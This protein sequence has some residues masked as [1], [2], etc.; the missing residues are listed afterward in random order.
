MLINTDVL[1]TTATI[2]KMIIGAGVISMP[3]TFSRLGYIVGMLFVACIIC[4]SQMASTFLIKVK[5][6][7]RRSNYPTI[8]YDITN[9]QC[10][11]IIPP[12]IFACGL[13]G[14]AIADMIILK[15]TIKSFVASIAKKE[16]KEWV[17]DQVYL[18][19]W[20]V[21]L[22]L[23][24]LETPFIRVKKIH[25]LKYL[26]FI[27]TT[28]ICFF[29]V[30]FLINFFLRISSEAIDWKCRSDFKPFNDNF[31][32]VIS[33]LPNITFALGFQSNF[34]PIYKGLKNPTDSRIFWACLVG[35]VTC[36]TF[37][38]IAGVTGFCLYG[39]DIEANF[40]QTLD[41][42]KTNILVYVVL[43]LAIVISVFC[44]LPLVYFTARNNCISICKIISNLIS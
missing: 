13:T 36:G 35:V 39:H 16:G 43:N 29:M 20:M 14:V 12:L 3:Y 5:N 28:G 10:L 30:F 15:G 11:K 27:G 32:E 38:T 6:L 4:I 19:N 34:F 8:F 31:L 21:I 40:L 24:I 22:F 18:S 1:L 23:G 17:A 44:S 42:E 25:K 7:A 9:S 26:S 33:A 41:L 2:I 37:Y